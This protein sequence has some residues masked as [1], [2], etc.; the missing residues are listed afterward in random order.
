MKVIS[1]LKKA[2]IK[3]NEPILLISAETAIENLLEAIENYCPNL[4]LDKMT[5]KDIKDLLYAYADCI[6]NYHPENYHQERAALLRNFEMLRK[7][8]LTD[9]DYNL[10]DF[11]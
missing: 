1:L 10:L 6:I 2:G 9:N 3:P 5:K 4:Q 8:G 11:V 7:Y